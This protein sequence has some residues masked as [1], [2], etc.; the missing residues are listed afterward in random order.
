MWDKKEMH[1][2][3]FG[4]L[5]RYVNG[6]QHK[7][8]IITLVSPFVIYRWNPFYVLFHKWLRIVVSLAAV[9]FSSRLLR[10]MITWLLLENWYF[11]TLYS[12][13]FGGVGFK[14]W[15]PH[16]NTAQLFGFS[17]WHAVFIAVINRFTHKKKISRLLFSTN[18][19]SNSY[20]IKE[21]SGLS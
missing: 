2:S 20:F 18:Q 14:W 16:H 9:H 11:E 6:I 4:A 17:L 21:D 1:K 7:C 15:I 13:N 10:L 19:Q 8:S 12:N 5:N 3:K